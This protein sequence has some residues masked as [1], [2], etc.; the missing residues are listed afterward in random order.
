MDLK[1]R[2]CAGLVVLLF[3][4]GCQKPNAAPQAGKPAATPQ[5][6]NALP[7]LNHAQPKLQ[8]IK[9]WLG[10]EE[11]VT[12]L[13]LTIEQISTGMMFR[14][15]MAE[16]EGMLFVFGRPH[17]TSFYMKNTTVPLS[18]AYIDPDGAIVEIHDLHPLNESPVEA[19]S[20]KI[21]Y[22]LEVPQGWFKRHNVGTGT[23]IRTERGTLPE[24]FFGKKPQQ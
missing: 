5:P 19:K 9:L 11:L 23:V 1:L 22:V 15:G 8:T 4:A 13:A 16:N 21:Q 14:K 6:T 20:E 3:F 10:A 12:E 17:R 24:L 18:S 7:H 2:M